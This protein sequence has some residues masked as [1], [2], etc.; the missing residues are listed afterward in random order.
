MLSFDELGPPPLSLNDAE[1]FRQ[2][3]PKSASP[4]WNDMSFFELMIGAMRTQKRA[5]SIPDT[6]HDA[7][8]RKLEL[9]T[10]FQQDVQTKYGNLPPN[11]SALQR[12]AAQAAF[13][14]T[15]AMQLIL[16]RPPY[17]QSRNIVPANDEF[18]ILENATRALEAELGAKA[19]DFAPWAWKSWVQ[20]YSLAIVLAELC[21]QPHGEKQDYAYEV[22]VQVFDR[23][24]MLIADDDHGAL[25]RP[26]AKLMRR[27][28]QLRGQ[29]LVSS[30]HAGIQEVQAPAELQLDEMDPKN[31]V[32]LLIND[33]MFDMDFFNFGQTSHELPTTQTT[34]YPHTYWSMFMDNIDLSSGYPSCI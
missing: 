14:L 16:R 1:M 28:Q 5:L 32:A 12:F 33:H 23:Y 13:A 34:W 22:A 15:T 9:V 27:V 3:V 31:D 18:G 21:S 17:K 6:N 30:N 24:S 20:W 29:S 19:T 2:N 25:W 4:G 7:W 26:I 10:A 8:I 11:A